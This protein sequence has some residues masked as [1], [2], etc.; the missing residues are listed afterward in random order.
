[1]AVTHGRQTNSAKPVERQQGERSD[2]YAEMAVYP[3]AALSLVAALIHL[4]V[5]PEHLEEWLGHGAFFLVVALAQGLGAVL[6]L[7][8]P[9]QPVFLVGILGNLAIIALYVVSRTSGLPFGAHS[10]VAE[11]AGVLDMSATA[12]ELGLVI[13][14]VTLLQGSHRSRVMNALLFLGALAWASRL[15]GVLP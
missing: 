11:E 1:M 8:W 2:S 6:L 15:L 7:R 9:K 10:G 12:A 5:V 13:A 4:W 14:L 3:A